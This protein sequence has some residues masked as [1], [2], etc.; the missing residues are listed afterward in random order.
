MTGGVSGERGSARQQVRS[1]KDL[2]AWRLCVDLAEAV[3]TIT[4]GFP[5]SETFGLQ[6]QMRRAAVSVPSNIAEGWGRRSRKD[7]VR[8]LRTARGSLFELRTQVEIARRV[9]FVAPDAAGQLRSDADRVGRVIYGLAS[10][11]Q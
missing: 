11:L 1:D 5:S 9:G 10:S 7:Y 2:D 4:A 8:F 3:Y 6:S